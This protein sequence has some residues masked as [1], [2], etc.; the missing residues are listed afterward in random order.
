MMIIIGR[1]LL[2]LL[3]LL[4]DTYLDL[5]DESF[6]I[7]DSSSKTNPLIHNILLYK[8]PEREWLYLEQLWLSLCSTKLIYLYMPRTVVTRY[9]SD[10]EKN[11]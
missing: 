9:M 11:I 10:N 2:D 7:Y 5:V 6:D 4:S 1:M 8:E 3:H